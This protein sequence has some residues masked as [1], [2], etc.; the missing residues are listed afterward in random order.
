MRALGLSLVLLLIAYAS[1]GTPV[2]TT[3][4][5]KIIRGY[6]SDEQCAGGRASSGVFTGTSPRCAKEC[7]AKGRKI[8]LVDPEAKQLLK[9]DNQSAALKNVG[10]YVEI[11]GGFNSRTKLLHID[12]LHLISTGVAACER[13]K[14]KTN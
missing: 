14:P 12:S 7:V 11:K 13:P 4:E 8:V 6:L 9:I 3:S 2:S 1:A 5:T 10:D